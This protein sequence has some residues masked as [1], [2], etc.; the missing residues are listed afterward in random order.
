MKS[1]KNIIIVLCVLFYTTSIN[2]QKANEANIDSTKAIINRLVEAKFNQLVI[3]SELSKIDKT[4][5]PDSM[6]V[7]GWFNHNSALIEF[8]KL[9]TDR[10]SGK[11]LAIDTFKIYNGPQMGDDQFWVMVELIDLDNFKKGD[12][13]NPYL[14]NRY[15][16]DFLAAPINGVWVYRTLRVTTEQADYTDELPKPTKY[17]LVIGNYIKNGFMGPND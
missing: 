4:S 2:A 15:F 12:T 10:L 8:N 9:L 14:N 7:Q 5:D 13:A 16:L 3:S 1:F 6:Y 11:R 17:R